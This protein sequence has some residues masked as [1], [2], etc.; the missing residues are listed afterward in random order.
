MKHPIRLVLFF[1]GITLLFGLIMIIFSK[2]FVLPLIMR[3]GCWFGGI[4][5]MTSMLPISFFFLVWIIEKCAF[6]K[7]YF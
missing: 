3:I 6:F 7:K 5:I 2:I 1:G 4:G